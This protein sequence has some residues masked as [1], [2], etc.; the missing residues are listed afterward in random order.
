[1]PNIL[2]PEGATKTYPTTWREPTSAVMKFNDLG[3]EYYYYSP[4]GAGRPSKNPVDLNQLLHYLC[5]D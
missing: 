4:D 3:I 5:R 1:M 2:E